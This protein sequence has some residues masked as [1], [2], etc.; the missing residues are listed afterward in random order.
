[1]RQNRIAIYGA[2]NFGRKLFDFFCG[3]SL[4][5]DCFIQS[6]DNGISEFLGKPVLSIKEVLD[7]KEDYLIFIAINDSSTVE[8]IQ[9][10]IRNS[11]YNMSHVFDMRSF[12]NDNSWSGRQVKTGDKECILCGN[13]IEQFLGAG[14][15]DD[16]FVRNKMIGGGYRENNICPCCK[17]M[18]RTRWVYWVLKNQTKI[19]EENATVIHFAPEKQLQ[20]KLQNNENC[21]Y[22]AGDISRRRGIHRI[23]VTDMPYKDNI[24]DYIIINHVMEHVNDEKKA[25]SELKR[26]LKDNGK[27]IMSFPISVTQKTFEDAAIISEADREKYYGQKDHVRLYGTDY[28]ERFESYGLKIRVFSPKDY[29]PDIEIEKYGL[30]KDDTVLICSQNRM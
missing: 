5:V 8:E 18:D 12:I 17:S 24:A 2:G 14:S 30:L 26:V 19:F 11:G 7:K 25:V 4:A 28:K 27:I 21:D 15:T 3:I 10:S 16:F 13:R 22:Y 1:M 23:D 6:D 20:I 29:L 9:V